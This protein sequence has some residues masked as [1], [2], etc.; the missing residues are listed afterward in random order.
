MATKKA[1]KSKAVAVVPQKQ[2]VVGG[3]RERAAASIAKGKAVSAKLPQQSGNFISFRNGSPSLGGVSLPN[4]LPLVILSY[5]FERS[6][7]SKPYQPDVMAAPDCYSYD[8]EVPHEKSKIPQSDRCSTCRLNEF[9]SAQNGKGKACKEG[10]KFAAIHA[11]SLDSPEKIAT[12]AIVQG[13]L[14]VLNSKGFRTYTGYFEESGQP[15]WGSVTSLIVTPDSKSQYAVRC[16]NIVAD[17]DDNDM[18]ALALRVDEAD[19]LLVQPYPDLDD[20]PAAKPKA[21]VPARKKKF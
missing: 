18:D 17:L 12:A 21:G 10:A 11:D 1:S 5:E 13:R 2:V 4:P 16:E 6:W 7:Y 3:W 9:G 8:G 19:K 14:S 20:A 15:I